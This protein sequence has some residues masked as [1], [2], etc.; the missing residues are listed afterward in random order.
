MSM[1]PPIWHLVFSCEVP[2][3]RARETWLNAGPHL[4]QLDLLAGPSGP[5]RINGSTPSSLDERMERKEDDDDD[6]DDD[7]ENPSQVLWGK[8][9]LSLSSATFQNANASSTSKVQVTGKFL[10]KSR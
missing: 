4:L 2:L 10:R 8:A 1:P 5:R 6:D 3:V 9:G 7:S